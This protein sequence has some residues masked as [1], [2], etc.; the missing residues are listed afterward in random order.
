MAIEQ[1]LC[2]TIDLIQAQGLNVSGEVERGARE[3][4]IRCFIQGKAERILNSDGTEVQADFTII[5]HKDQ[6]LTIGAELENGYDQAGKVI[7]LAA[8]CIIGIR[9]FLHPYKGRIAR[10]VFVARN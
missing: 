1:K 9:D 6:D 8:G 5:F 4:G 3:T 10:S 7:L 2:H